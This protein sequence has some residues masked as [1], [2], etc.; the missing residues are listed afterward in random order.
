MIYNDEDPVKGRFVD[1]A[2]TARLAEANSALADKFKDIAAQDIKLLLDG[3]TFDLLGRTLNILGLKKTKTIL[4]ATIATLPR[5]SPSRAALPQ[6]ASFAQL[7]IQNLEPVQPAAGHDQRADPGRRSQM[8]PA[9]LDAFYFAAAVA[10]AVS[11]MFVTMLLAPGCWRSSAR[12]TPSRGWCA[13]SS[14]ADDRC[15]REDAARPPR[16]RSPSRW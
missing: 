4:D 15:W 11:L 12:R 16:A 8:A 14:R 13:G 1:Q 5:G 7:A 3:G 9:P 6:V 10:V 2:I